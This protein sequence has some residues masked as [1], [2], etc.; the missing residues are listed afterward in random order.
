MGVVLFYWRGLV[1]VSWMV[2]EACCRLVF[3]LGKEGRRR[4]RSGMFSYRKHFNF[5]ECRERI[6]KFFI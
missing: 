5:E 1:R 3:R 6:V 4:E 2:N